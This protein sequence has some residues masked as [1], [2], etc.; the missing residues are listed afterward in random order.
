MWWTSD[1]INLTNVGIGQVDPK[2]A[3]TTPIFV[4]V[5]PVCLRNCPTSMRMVISGLVL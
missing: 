5:L 1:G 3:V 2:W 4:R